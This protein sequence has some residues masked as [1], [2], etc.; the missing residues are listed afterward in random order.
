MHW[1]RVNRFRVWIIK[2]DP[3]F[4]DRRVGGGIG[5]SNSWMICL[6]GQGRP[7][8]FEGEACRDKEK[9]QQKN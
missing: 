2:S 6:I 4:C 8:E 7:E 1:T 3:D 5:Y 9:Q